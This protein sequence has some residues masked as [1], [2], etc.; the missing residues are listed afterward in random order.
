[1][2]RRP[3]RYARILL[4]GGLGFLLAGCSL[5]RPAPQTLSMRELPD[6]LV[7]APLSDT[8]KGIA[9]VEMTENARRQNFRLAFA[10]S[11]ENR[12]RLSF[13]SPFG[14]PLFDIVA[15]P[16]GITMHDHQSGRTLRHQDVTTAFRRITGVPMEVRDLYALLNNR[17]PVPVHSG[18]IPS[19]KRPR[20]Y[21]LLDARNRPV[22][23]VELAEDGRIRELH[24]L[25]QKKPTGVSI[26]REGD[27]MVL[28][29]KGTHVRIHI[30]QAVSGQPLKAGTF[31]LT[32]P[33]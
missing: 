18:V 17:I 28:Q 13:L 30:L 8:V 15:T 16:E 32:P 11:V 3:S 12:V 10:G 29:S 4:V 5:N 24:P 6:A 27:A 19:P 23:R 31:V 2:T 20:S 14:L 25:K 33:P 1:M 9:R 21:H 26:K 7:P 22:A